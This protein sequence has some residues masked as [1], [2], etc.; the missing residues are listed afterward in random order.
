M[1]YMLD[2]HLTVCQSFLKELRPP[3]GGLREAFKESLGQVDSMPSFPR[4][5]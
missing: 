4:E 2:E 1:F 3:T 5:R